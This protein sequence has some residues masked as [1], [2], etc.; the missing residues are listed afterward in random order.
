MKN[1]GVQTP[2]ILDDIIL[3]GQQVLGGVPEVGIFSFDN[4]NSD[5]TSFV[6]FPP[7][8]L[9]VFNMSAVSNPSGPTTTE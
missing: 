1:T 7:P 4:E 9:V 6:R 2:L 5:V 3:Q 8:L